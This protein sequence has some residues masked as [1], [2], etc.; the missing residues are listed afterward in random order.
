M[1]P[2][3]PQDIAITLTLRALQKSVPALNVSTHAA[4]RILVLGV[5]S[6]GCALSRSLLSYGFTSLTLVDHGLVRPSN[7][8]RQCL[9]TTADIGKSKVSTAAAALSSISSSM[10]ISPVHLSI[11]TPGKGSPTEED[12]AALTTLIKAST[13][14]FLCTDTRESRFIPTILCS[15]YNTPAISLALAIDHLVVVRH[16]VTLAGEEGLSESPCPAPKEGGCFFC[17]DALAPTPSF[18]PSHPTLDTCASTKPPLAPIAANIA[19]EL[20]VS[21]LSHPLSFATPPMVVGVNKL[22]VAEAVGPCYGLL[23][24]NLTSHTTLLGLNTAR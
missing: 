2:A 23:R 9:F 4:Q 18:N 13:T 21:I 10:H 14:V 20:L 8:H 6:L 24:H 15:F 5:G 7:P 17:V 19:V 11:P 3:G 16:G 12:L 1:K 22:G